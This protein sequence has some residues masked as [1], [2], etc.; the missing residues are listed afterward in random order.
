LRFQSLER[1]TFPYPSGV[2]WIC[3][4]FVTTTRSF[5]PLAEAH[6]LDP[7]LPALL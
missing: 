7:L 2:I 5:R 6:L 1:D 4:K 3:R